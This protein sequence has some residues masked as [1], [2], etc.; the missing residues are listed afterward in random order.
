MTAPSRQVEDSVLAQVFQKKPAEIVRG[1]NALLFG[2]QGERYIDL[3]ANYGVANVGHA[4]P[5]VVAAIREQAAH[6]IHLAQTLYSPVRADFLRELQRILP[7]R[8]PR[9]FLANSGTEAVEAALKWSRASTKRTQFVAFR[10]AFHG[11]TYGA[12]SATWKPAYRE[13]FEPLVPGFQ[14]VPF[15]DAAALESAVTDETAAVL[16]E[17]VQGEGGVHPATAE[18]L[19]AARKACDD[20][21]SLLILDEIQTGLGRTGRTWAHEHFHVDPDILLV[22]KSIAGGL[23]MG[24]AALREDV[25]TAMPKA[26]HGNTFGGGPLV[27]A[28]ATATLQ[29][30]REERLAQRAAT[31]GAHTMARLRKANLPLVRDVRGL[32]LMVGADLRIKPQPILEALL[33]RGVLALPAGTTVLRLLPP[34]TIPPPLLD[35]G[36][37]VVEDVLRAT[38]VA[39][40]QPVEA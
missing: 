6:L 40:A 15:N 12:L 3:G 19:R 38:P 10:N 30:L 39:S 29:I 31:E 8:T 14:F 18:F 22:G 26:A 7:R 34:L 13:P 16:L 32:G 11:R 35:E 2:P 20:H 5:R 28:A 36:L 21:G 27:C 37:T 33:R 4:H 17:P 25:A 24:L 9:A 23:P 1:E